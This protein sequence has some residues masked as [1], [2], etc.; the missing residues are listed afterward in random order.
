MLEQTRDRESIPIHLQLPA[1]LNS[2]VK[3]LKERATARGNKPSTRGGSE[4]LSHSGEMLTPSTTVELL[5]KEGYPGVVKLPSGR[6]TIVVFQG[7]AYL[8][9]LSYLID[10]AS[11]F[12]RRN[13]GWDEQ[14]CRE[15]MIKGMGIEDLTRGAKL[16]LETVAK[17]I[18]RKER[19]IPSAFLFRSEDSPP[20]YR[21]DRENL[22]DGYYADYFGI[23]VQR[24][25][26]L[27][28]DLTGGEVPVL[29]HVLRAFEPGAR[30]KRRGRVSV[31]LALIRHVGARYY[32]HQT[33]NPIAAYTNTRSPYLVQ[34]GVHPWTDLSISDPLT[35]E[36]R[37]KASER[38]LLP[39]RIMLPT[40]VVKA[41]YP[42]PNRGF[43][44]AEL[45][46]GA[47]DTYKF[48]K[49]TLG[50]HIDYED[51]YDGSEGFDSVA[52]LYMV[53]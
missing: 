26:F 14:F 30:D 32:I 11:I 42:Q 21:K 46:G 6:D 40:G 28:T 2:F 22:P 51:G 7:K 27:K 37:E 29:D 50:M 19:K 3:A 43:R 49:E 12:L 35:K 1:F 17:I 44:P 9:N 33:G 23:S 24:M 16:D 18:A 48:M 31:A 41:D 8:D 45:R 10:T 38:I 4:G 47:G 39:G 15:R 20:E 13:V 25:L 52:P 5:S 36:I 34:E 53:R